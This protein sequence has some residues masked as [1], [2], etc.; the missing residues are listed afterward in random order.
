MIG[1]PG[2]GS[3]LLDY[4]RPIDLCR[5]SEAPAVSAAVDEL[6]F[7]VLGT[8]AARR[9]RWPQRI[10]HLRIALLN[11][12]HHHYA[13]HGA[14]T[15]YPRNNMSY[16]GLVP[17][18]N[19]RG[20]TRRFV[21]VIDGLAELGYIEHFTG[22]DDR[23]AGGSSRLSRMRAK[24]A[25]IEFMDKHG[26]TL[27]MSAERPDREVIVLRADSH[28]IDYVETPETQVAICVSINDYRKCLVLNLKRLG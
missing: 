5:W 20:V 26:I 24:P 25:L 22:F 15:A 28:D 21:K 14:F 10:T 18:Y 11:L 12:Y 13:L 27:A 19:P 7:E 17:R 9:T 3:N 4:Y 16:D 6:A 1:Q 23:K 2:V 8:R